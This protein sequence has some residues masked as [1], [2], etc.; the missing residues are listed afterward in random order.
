[1]VLHNIVCTKFKTKKKKLCLG[2]R[3][4]SKSVEEK[5][6]VVSLKCWQLIWGETLYDPCLKMSTKS[7]KP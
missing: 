1:M 2:T 6:G 4:R 3:T 7:P 5:V